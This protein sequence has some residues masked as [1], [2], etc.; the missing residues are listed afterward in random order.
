MN[1]GTSKFLVLHIFSTVEK[2]LETLKIQ[3][4]NNVDG[5]KTKLEKLEI[6]EETSKWWLMTT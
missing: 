4:Q 5:M 6:D 2:D 1:L 3:M